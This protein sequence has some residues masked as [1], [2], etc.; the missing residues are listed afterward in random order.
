MND[1]KLGGGST[2][3]GGFSTHFSRP[4]Y[5]QKALTGYL[6]RV[7]NTSI[8][9]NPGYNRLGR[10]YPDVAVVS[11]N[12]LVVMDD[13]TLIFSGTSASTPVVGG[14]ISLVNAARFNAGLSAVGW[15]NPTLYSYYQSFTRDVTSGNNKCTCCSPN[16]ICCS[17]GYTATTGWD[18]ASGFGSID[19]GLLLKFMMPADYVFPTEN[20]TTAPTNI[21]TLM[22]SFRPSVSPSFQPTSSPTKVPS[23]KPT[24]NPS[25][26]PTVTPFSSPTK[27]P[28][29]TP[30]VLSTQVPTAV[31]T[32]MPTRRLR[33]ILRPTFKPTA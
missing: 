9:P 5:Q 8:A 13:N 16:P 25:A 33:P 14:M 27:K 24:S 1:S 17:E 28:S 21:P 29:A 22:P 11:V 10:G 23:I 18:P 30:T 31:P 20:P 26:I 3:G 6:A 15:F 12:Y 32:A 4:F 19:V 2:A 7:D